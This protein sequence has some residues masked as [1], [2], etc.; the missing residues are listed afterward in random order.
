MHRHPA[1]IYLSEEY[2]LVRYY[3]HRNVYYANKQCRHIGG[4]D[5]TGAYMIAFEKGLVFARDKHKPTA[6]ATSL[7]NLLQ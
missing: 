1:K 7:F 3:P 5:L 2:D 4:K 6:L